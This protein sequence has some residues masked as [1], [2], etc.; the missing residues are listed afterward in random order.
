MKYINPFSHAKPA[1]DDD[2]YQPPY[3][4]ICF[5]INI[6]SKKSLW[7]QERKKSPPFILLYL[8]LGEKPVQ[9]HDVKTRFSIYIP[10]SIIDIEKI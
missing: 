2:V 6:Y 9:G 5:K 3:P 4:L 10:I 7:R 1:V 8:S